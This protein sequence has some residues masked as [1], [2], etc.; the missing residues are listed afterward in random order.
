MDIDLGRREVLSVLFKNWKQIA[1]LFFGVFAVFFGGSYL[2]TSKYKA[3]TRILVQTGREFEVT[4]DQGNPAPTGVPYVTKQEIVNSEVEILSGRDL[5]ENVIRAVGLKRIYPSIADDGDPEPVQMNDATK[6][7]GKNFK[8]EPV[9]MSNIITLQY[10]NPDRDIAIE[11]LQKLAGAYEQEHAKI[12][13]NKRAASICAT[14]GRLREAAGEGNAKDHRFK[15]FRAPSSD[16][17]YE[18]DQLIQDRSDVEAKLRDL[19]AQSIEAIELNRFTGSVKSMPELVLTNQNSADAVETANPRL[20]DLN[21]QLLQL[22]QR[23][24]D[25][26]PD[27]VGPRRS[28]EADRADQGVHQRPNRESTKGVGPQRH[29]RRRAHEAAK[30][31][32]RGTGGGSE[33]RFRDLAEEN[34]IAG[35]LQALDDRRGKSRGADSRTVD[36]TRVGS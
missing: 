26:N 6:Q 35:R 31:R 17:A 27:A 9:T 8:A 5:A 1:I 21:T 2:L 24:A 3:Q 18:R 36:V 34:R 19:K 15:R 14:G 33:N 12:F 29:L 13:S 23:Y 25:G 28:R 4:T 22:K 30:R 20:L 7:Y 11:A 32:R 10:W 16:I